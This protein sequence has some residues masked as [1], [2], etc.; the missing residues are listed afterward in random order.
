MRWLRISL[1]GV[2]A[3][4]LA[5]CRTGS[6]QFQATQAIPVPPGL[7]PIGLYCVDD[8]NDFPT[9]R[10]AGFNVITGPAAREFLDAAQANGLQVLARP[11]TEAGTKFDAGLARRAVG[12]FDMHPALWAWYLVD[13]PDLNLI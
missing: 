1:A 6:P 10:A 7:F 12:N 3:V 8:T 11:D 13:E 5:G 2:V 9:V 4:A